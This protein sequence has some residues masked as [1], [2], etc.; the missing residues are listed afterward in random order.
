MLPIWTPGD[1]S[2]L[3]RVSAPSDRVRGNPPRSAEV[4]GIPRAIWSQ[5]L[6]R[7]R[8]LARIKGNKAPTKSDLKGK[9]IGFT[10]WEGQSL[11]DGRPLI[12]VITLDSDNV[13]TGK[14]YQT[15]ILLRDTDPVQA[16]KN[17]MDMSACGTCPHQ[18]ALVFDP[19][20]AAL[21]DRDPDAKVDEFHG[22]VGRSCYV[23][24]GK[25]PLAVWKTYHRGRYPKISPEEAAW[26]VGGDYLR[27]G[28]YGDPAAVPDEVW[29]PMVFRDDGTANVAGVTGYTHAWKAPHAQVYK[30]YLMASADSIEDAK[31]AAFMGWRY[32][33]VRKHGEP[34]LQGELQCP[35]SVEWTIRALMRA[36][37]DPR[38]WFKGHRGRLSVRDDAPPL[39]K[40]FDKTC[41]D[42]LMCGG[43]ATALAKERPLLP[44]SSVT[45]MGH[46]Q[47]EQF[48][49]MDAAQREA[50][51]SAKRS[52]KGLPMAEHRYSDELTDEDLEALRRDYAIHEAPP[53]PGF[54]P[55]PPWLRGNPASKASLARAKAR[56]H[57]L[58]EAQRAGYRAAKASE[59]AHGLASV[60]ETPLAPCP[61]CRNT[62]SF[63][64][65]VCPLCDGGRARGNPYYP[66]DGPPWPSR[67]W[68]HADDREGA[69]AFAHRRYGRAVGP[70]YPQPRCGEEL[71][72]APPS[73]CNPWTPDG[74]VE[75][76][77]RLDVLRAG[78]V[79]WSW[80]LNEFSDD[81]GS[82]LMS[83]ARAAADA[84]KI[85]P[86]DV[87]RVTI[88]GETKEFKAQT[89][90]SNP[91]GRSNPL[92]RDYLPGPYGP[93][94]VIEQ[95]GELIP[96]SV[97]SRIYHHWRVVADHFKTKA[98]AKAWCRKRARKYLNEHMQRK[99]RDNPLLA[100]IGV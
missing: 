22:G 86:G 15:W 87:L 12:C 26:L 6:R 42:C 47:A 55:A 10:L 30:D 88:R 71:S 38:P 37:I 64:E 45:I 16:S 62:G 57:A 84:G 67:Q 60:R 53:P 93:W 43:L 80:E 7:A 25:A 14:L 54:P 49:G 76:Y 69:D 99:K 58:W 78:R 61:L 95:D 32:F 5:R 46:G 4:G 28:S 2:P 36:G 65:G 98:E 100:V 20:A 50:R 9:V 82:L 94:F 75:G 63:D 17:H 31:E 97:S 13:K 27:I 24:L 74:W 18:G 91:C 66:V 90:R 48:V 52:K 3:T 68:V 39:P 35:A 11:F 40:K 70:G 56:R 33:R 81:A 83:A 72:H 59:A 29:R 77:D 44:S 1:F 89:K 34:V 23:D 96:C 19:D 79:V 51:V 8:E 92:V 21:L 85:K 73:R 41:M